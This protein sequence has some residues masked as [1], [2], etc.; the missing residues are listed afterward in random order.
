MTSNKWVRFEHNNTI[1]FGTLDDDLINVY[2][3]DVFA[4]PAA[5]GESLKLSDVVL[6]APVEPGKMVA[7]INNFH[8]LIEKLGATVPQEPHYFFKSNSSFHPPGKTIRRPAGYDGK[9]IFEGELGIVIGKKCKDVS[10]EDAKSYIFG[11]TC[12]NDVTSIEIL[13]REA[14]FAQWTRCKA[15]DTYGVIGPAIATNL[16]YDNIRV[17]ASLRG[18]ERQNYP[19]T[20]MVFNELELISAISKDMT[21]YP[22]DIIA[23]GTSVGVGSMRTGDVIEITIDGIGTLSNTFE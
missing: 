16:D 20:D 10:V 18:Q 14:I 23:C 17:K 8:E 15:A 12:V 21:L 7:M 11:Y 9:I 3:G 19:I 1:G 2:T 6:I 22:G 13:N 5:T 4:N